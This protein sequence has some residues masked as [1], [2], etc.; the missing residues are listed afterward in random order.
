MT[1]WRQRLMFQAVGATPALRA[2]GH[3]PLHPL[4]F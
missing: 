4:S 3:S 1:V 2:E